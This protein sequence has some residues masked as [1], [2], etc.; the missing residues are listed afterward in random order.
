MKEHKHYWL[1]SGSYTL[2]MNMQSFLFGFGG[3]YLLVRMLDKHHFGIWT[4]FVA[5]TSVFEMARNGLV[6]N[7]LIKFLSDNPEEEKPKIISASF[8]LSGLLMI[9]CIILNVSFAGYFSRLWHFPEMVNMFLMFNLVYLLGGFLSQFQ[10]IEQANLQFRGILI[11]TFIRQ[12]GY[13]FYILISFILHWDISLMSLIY[14]QCIATGLATAVQY[15]I[16]RPM[17][18]I[19]YEWHYEWVRKLFNYG[20][21][22]FGIFVGSILSSSVN[23][24]MLGTMVSTDAAGSYNLAL[25]IVGLTDIPINAMGTIVFPQ[26]ARRFA[27]QGK[28]AG[29][30]LYEKSVGTILAILLPFVLF[31]LIF[32]GFVV[33]IIAGTNYADAIPLVQFVIITCLL[34][35]FIRLFGTILDSIGKTRLNFLIMII[36]AVINLITGYLMIKHFGIMG[37]VYGTA[38]ADTIICFIMLIIV[39]KELNVNALN[40]FIYAGRFYPEFLKSYVRPLLGKRVD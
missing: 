39:Y 28:S 3:F 8:V 36:F 17:L 22:A 11:T 34:N 18:F 21:F 26:S 35:P 5:I 31:I 12:G 4:L 33:R 15:F 23:Q 19:S 25:R 29:K 16:V 24:V 30:Y 2:V 32:P 9:F 14:V 20:K 27:E 7:A 38:V 37:C 1:K 13:F 40:T 6:P 10:S